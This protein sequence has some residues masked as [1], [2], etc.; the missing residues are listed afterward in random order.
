[1]THTVTIAPKLFAIDGHPMSVSHFTIESDSF[2]TPEGIV[3]VTVT[4]HAKV[5]GPT[6]QS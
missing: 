5:E 3:E 1:M 6:K 2:F 4:F